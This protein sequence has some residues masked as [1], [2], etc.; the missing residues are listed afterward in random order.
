M[1]IYVNRETIRKP[2]GGGAHYVNAIFDNCN[3]NVVIDDIRTFHSYSSLQA[4]G[5]AV[6]LC[7][8]LDG[9]DKHPVVEEMI[10]Y[11]NYV[12]DNSSTSI[13]FCIRVNECDARKGTVGVDQRVMKAIA[14]ADG[15]IFVSEWMRDYYTSLGAA[16]KQYTVI[17]N[18]VDNEIYHKNDKPKSSNISVVTHHWSNNQMKGFDIYDELDRALGG[19]LGKKIDFTYVGRDRGTFKNTKVV[20]PLYG[21][22][23]GNELRKHNVYIS[24]SRFDPG[25]N[26][27]IEALAC[28]DNV[29]VHADG[30]G[31]VEFAGNDATYRTFDELVNMILSRKS[32]ANAKSFGSWEQCAKQTFEF[33]KLVSTK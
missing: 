32:N 3:E 26:H 28:F 12:R 8:G 5:D 11:R 23:L 33:L 13:K 17:Y 22:A 1:I 20:Q 4:R 16:P 21:D 29:Y 27:I 10:N 24:A 2:W 25:P 19:E 14:E 6:M 18:G 30:G 31:C 7:C 15:V 9:D